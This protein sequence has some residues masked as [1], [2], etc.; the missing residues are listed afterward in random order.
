MLRVSHK[1]YGKCSSK[2]ILIK[3]RPFLPLSCTFSL[4][5]F[6][7][8]TILFRIESCMS[9]GGGVTLEALAV[10]L[11]SFS[12]RLTVFVAKHY[13]KPSKLNLGLGSPLSFLFF[14][15]A[16]KDAIAKG[17]RESW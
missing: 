5:S 2:R 9:L 15:P 6:N 14:K 12:A 17:A 1:K 16:A 8:A 13:S 4:L 3:P 10:A 7:I 11:F